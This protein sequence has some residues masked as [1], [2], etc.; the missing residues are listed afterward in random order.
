VTKILLWPDGVDYGWWLSRPQGGQ[1]GVTCPKRL[2]SRDREAEEVA[3]V[4]AHWGEGGNRKE[5][6]GRRNFKDKE[7]RVVKS[8]RVKIEE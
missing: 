8:R 1:G 6:E 7:G 5:G 3:V 2:G 4:A